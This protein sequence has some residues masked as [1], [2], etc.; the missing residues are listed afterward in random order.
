MQRLKVMIVDDERMICELIRKLVDWD[1]LNLELAAMVNNGELA[2]Q[3]AQKLRPDIVITDIRMPGLDGLSLIEKVSAFL[4]DTKFIIV[5]GY[6]EFDYAMKAMKFGVKDYLLKPIQKKMLD[7]ALEKLCGS[8]SGIAPY[9]IP[10]TAAAVQAE[11]NFGRL[12]TQML[13]DAM[14]RPLELIE[15]TV[16]PIRGTNGIF[17]V[18][19]RYDTRS[20]F[21]SEDPSGQIAVLAS[22]VEEE[23]KA[24]FSEKQIPIVSYVHRNETILLVSVPKVSDEVLTVFTQAFYEAQERASFYT[25]LSVTMGIGV[26][27][28]SMSMVK[29]TVDAARMAVNQRVDNGTDRIIDFK[30]VRLQSKIYGERAKEAVFEELQK[31]VGLVRA[32]ELSKLDTIWN[33]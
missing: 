29:Q 8:T 2:L 32:K 25:E 19:I 12:R 11:G 28:H 6:K 13:I 4:P 26:A 17:A 20:A 24:K 18:I 30:D 15:E 3:T 33:C 23:I 22:K 27:V 7:E 14:G 31:I 9:E 10:T 5:S 21:S 1:R 16:A